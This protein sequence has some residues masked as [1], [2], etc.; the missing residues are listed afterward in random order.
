M[1][2]L[3]QAAKAN[4]TGWEPAPAS[5]GAG[6]PPSIPDLSNT[7]GRSPNMLAA[8]P[9]Q[10]TTGDGL[11]RQFYGGTN[12]PTMRILPAAGKGVA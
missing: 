5:P 9:P 4:M 6:N 7:P 10:A 11:Q 3:R 2:S 1:A 8:M 12:I